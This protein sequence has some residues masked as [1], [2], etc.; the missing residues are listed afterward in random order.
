[1]KRA[2]LFLLIGILCLGVSWAAF[3]SAPPEEPAFSRFFPAGA[4]SLSPL[5]S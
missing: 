1:M 5:Y 2:L 4:L 3:Q